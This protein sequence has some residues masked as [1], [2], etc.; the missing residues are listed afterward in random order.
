MPQVWLVTGHSPDP[1]RQDYDYRRQTTDAFD[2]CLRDVRERAVNGLK[3]N[4]S[5]LSELPET[6]NR[7]RGGWKKLAALVSAAR[8][9]HGDG[10]LVW[11][12]ADA[13]P[14]GN[15]QIVERASQ[16]AREQPSVAVWLQ[17][18]KRVMSK[19]G[20][21]LLTHFPGIPLSRV[22]TSLTDSNSLQTGVILMRAAFAMS[23]MGTALKYY[24]ANAERE[25][26]LVSHLAR[27]GI[28][29]GLLGS[30]EQGPLTHHLVRYH[31]QQVQL[32][33]WLQCE[34]LLGCNNS[35]FVPSFLHYSGCSFSTK[36]AR[37]CL[38][39]YCQANFSLHASW[40]RPQQS[41]H[42]SSRAIKQLP[43]RSVAGCCDRHPRACS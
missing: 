13:V 42:L 4:V 28:P 29:T 30:Q 26:R 35:W 32:V 36:R 2:L 33:S 24:D 14:N 6:A 38:S 7:V 9:C 37:K 10:L 40:R 15:G 1:V 23:I 12:D 18:G 19:A 3:P 43:C 11:H 20:S 17:P 22:A 39:R 34:V 41:T 16:I 21:A 27:L 25:G 8:A 5:V 31:R